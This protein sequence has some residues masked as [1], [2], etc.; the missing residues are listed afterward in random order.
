M[1][2][3]WSTNDR[4][5][6]S[7]GEVSAHLPLNSEQRTQG[8]SVALN[9][10]G[11]SMEHDQSFLLSFVSFGHWNWSRSPK[12]HLTYLLPSF[13]D[14][15]SSGTTFHLFFRSQTFTQSIV[16]SLPTDLLLSRTIRV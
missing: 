15:A 5:Q 7:F 12:I 10:A 6:L 13:A 3:G 11:T 2:F 9:S 1:K 16:F 8:K 4:R 14:L